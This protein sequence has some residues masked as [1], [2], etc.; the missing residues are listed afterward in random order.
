MIERQQARDRDGSQLAVVPTEQGLLARYL[1]EVRQIPLLL[2]AAEAE[3]FRLLEEGDAERRR[4]ARARLI[5]ANLRLVVSVARHY[6]GA[7]LPL[8]ELIAEGN[9]GLI[10]AVDRFERA[11]G[12]RFSTY[13]QW[14]IRKA[15]TQA[16]DERGRLVRLPSNS[17]LALRRL[18]RAEEALPAALGREP[19][20]AELAEACGV[21]AWRCDALRRAALPSLS[22]DAPAAG[23]GG[24]EG[25]LGETLADAGAALPDVVGRRIARD[26]V[27]RLLRALPPRERAVLVLRYGLDGGAPRTLKQVG[28]AIG[29]SGEGTRRLEARALKQLRGHPLSAALRG[30]L[31]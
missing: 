5:A 18:R 31:D 24:E 29:L 13:A 7:G 2:P 22:L 30:S 6:L 26:Q 4:A 19:T 27:D 1:H 3:L 23:G 28:A 25:A 17:W 21:A 15:I 16:L 10:A 20:A 9:L 11:R 12:C 14:R 8:P